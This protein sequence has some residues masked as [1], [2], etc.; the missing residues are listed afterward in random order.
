L[1]DRFSPDLTS[2]S[3][4][5]T[6]VWK[7][8]QRMTCETQ[9]GC[10]TRKFL[11]AN[12]CKRFARRN[13]GVFPDPFLAGSQRQQM[14]RMPFLRIFR[15]QRTHDCFVIR[16]RK[17]GEQAEFCHFDPLFQYRCSSIRDREHTSP[18]SVGFPEDAVLG[19]NPPRLGA[20]A[21]RARGP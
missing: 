17:D 11:G 1:G 4:G 16:M 20:D 13:P 2:D 5:K 18:A 7:L 9:L 3:G 19:L 8:E 15:E 6:L 10:G 12:R 14:D 21:I